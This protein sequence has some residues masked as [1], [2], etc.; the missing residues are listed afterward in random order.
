[1]KRKLKPEDQKTLKA[2]RDRI[3]LTLEFINETED[4]GI[5]GQKLRTKT[6]LAFEKGNL[7]GM[8]LMAREIDSFTVAMAAHQR[9]GLEA[10]L[11]ARLGVDKDY[12]RSKL[13]LKVAAVIKRGSIS[14]EKERRRLED[15]LEMLEATGGDATEAEAVRMLLSRH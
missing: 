13:R 3:V 2:L 4:S 7:R 10:I 9:D 12:E 8:R 14:S 1:M 15:Y 11:K 5:I 6:D